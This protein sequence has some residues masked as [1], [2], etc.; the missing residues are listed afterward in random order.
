MTTEEIARRNRANASKSTGPRTQAGK[1]TVAQNA[2]RHG[3]T[4]RPDRESVATWLSIILDTVHIE[5]GHVLPEDERGYRA[6]ALAEAEVKHAAAETALLDFE[7]GREQP[8]EQIQDLKYQAEDIS[9]ILKEFDMSV[10]ERN[11]GLSVMARISRAVIEDAAHG[12]KRHRLLKRYLGEAR[13]Q[14]R[15]AFAAWLECLEGKDVSREAA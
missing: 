13:A 15:K 2:R 7:G 4:A 3:A 1:A 6:L 5:G 9:D 12:G 11:K 8:S 14:R 10:R